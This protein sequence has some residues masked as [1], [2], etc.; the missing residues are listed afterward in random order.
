MS[1]GER[2]R[3]ASPEVTEPTEDAPTAAPEKKRRRRQPASGTAAAAAEPAPAPQAQAQVATPPA[4][5]QLPVAAQNQGQMT[6]AG[7]SAVQAQ[8]NAG[9]QV[10]PSGGSKKGTLAGRCA[11]EFLINPSRCPRHYS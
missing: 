9:A 3:S 2:S 1:D 7:P 6:A 8:P 10:A 11:M 4:P 5:A